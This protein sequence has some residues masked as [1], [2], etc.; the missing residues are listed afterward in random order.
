V[1][2]GAEEAVDSASKRVVGEV[3]QDHRP[4]GWAAEERPEALRR[5]AE[6]RRALDVMGSGEPLVG[7]GLAHLVLVSGDVEV[8]EVHV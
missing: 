5:C 6:A 7:R 1:E 4:I 2:E 3:R 8:A